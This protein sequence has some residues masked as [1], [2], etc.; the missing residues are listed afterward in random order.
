MSNKRDIAVGAFVLFGLIA[1][2]V[3]VIVIGNERRQTGDALS[4]GR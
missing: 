4:A 3:V 2:S 1:T